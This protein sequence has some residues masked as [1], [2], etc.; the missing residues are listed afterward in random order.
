MLLFP[1]AGELEF[2]SVGSR[3]LFSLCDDGIGVHFKVHS[4][5]EFHVY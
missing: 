5:D 2:S 4:E 1:E 3:L